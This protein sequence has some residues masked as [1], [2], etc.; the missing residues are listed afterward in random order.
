VHKLVFLDRSL[1]NNVQQALFDLGRLDSRP[2][3]VLDG[4]TQQAIEEAEFEFDLDPKDGLPDGDLLRVLRAKTSNGGE[5]KQM[6]AAATPPDEAA[7][8]PGLR[9]RIE[10]LL[11]QLDYFAGPPTG[12]ATIDSDQAIWEAER[13]FGLEAD[14][15]PDKELLRFLSSKA[16]GNG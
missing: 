7:D 11:V 2:S 4:E 6:D 9:M 14:G 3:R 12:I 13:D 10:E 15:V 16:R 8:D 5:A 1:I